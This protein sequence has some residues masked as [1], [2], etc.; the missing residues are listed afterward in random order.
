LEQNARQV[1]ITLS[2][3]RN[4]NH[5]HIYGELIGGGYPHADV[6]KQEDAQ[7]VQKAIYYS[8]CNEFYAFDVLM[9]GAEYLNVDEAN[10]LLEDHGFLYVK[11]LFRGSLE[12]CLAHP[13]EFKTTI[14]EQLGLPAIDGNIAE[15]VVIRPVET[16]FLNGGSRI[17]IKNKT[18]KWSE[19]NAQIDRELLSA[20][21]H[22]QISPEAEQLTATALTYVSENRLDNLISKLGPPSSRNRYGKYLGMFNRDVLTDFKK[23][24]G[25]AYDNLEKHEQKHINKAVNVA[26]GKVVGK[27]FKDFI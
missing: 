10:Q 15:G 8:S 21:L 12:D 24:R 25:I 3:K 18:E 14:P 16:S 13:H 11:E 2:R 9:D 23:D 1:F 17:L 7:L 6:H 4:L 20:I 27:C 19:N 5:L 26:A 22:E